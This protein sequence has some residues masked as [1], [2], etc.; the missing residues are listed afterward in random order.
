MQT[1]QTRPAAVAGAFYPAEPAVLAAAVSALLDHASLVSPV[2][3]NPSLLKAMI[4][5]H[6]GYIYSGPIAAD[7]Y[8]LLAG[9]AMPIRRV[10]LI[11][12]AHRVAVRGVALP[13]CAAFRTPLGEV[14][15][16]QQ[17][18]GKLAGL[19]Q[20]VMSA[21]AHA[22]EHCIEVHLPFLQQLLADF[23]IVPLLVGDASPSQVADVLSCLWGGDETLIIVSSDLSHYLPYEIGRRVDADTCAHILGMHDTISHDEACGATAILG[24]LQVA[25]QRGLTPE[26]IR[27]A[28][29][30]DTAGDKARVVGYASFAFYSPQVGDT[31]GRALLA[32]ARAAIAMHLGL[33][34]PRAATL[35]EAAHQPGA[36]F[37][38]LMLDGA[39]RGCIGSLEARRPLHEDVAAN[40]VAAASRDPRFSPVTVDEFTRLCVE[41]SVLTPAEPFTVVDEMDAYRRLLP[42]RDGVILAY[43]AHQATFLPQVWEQLPDPADFLMQLKLKAGLAGDFWS[44]DVRLSRY[45]VEKWSERETGAGHG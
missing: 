41:V 25:R 40:A 10:V 35:P 43:G 11:G 19:P 15:V 14:P 33:D 2:G 17:A 34:P 3:R 5:P 42:G 4:L 6:A 23:S 32:H 29:S 36:S 30:G 37:V 12:P 22:S 20:V 28:S 27:I 31:F 8:R 1:T 9:A 39:L 26:L 24:L 38:T 45:R 7:G 44:P 16:D 18:V 13:D 21:A